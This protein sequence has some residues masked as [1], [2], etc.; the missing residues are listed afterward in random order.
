MTFEQ[1]LARTEEL[2]EG[3]AERAM[4]LLRAGGLGKEPVSPPAP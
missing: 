1:S 4:R 2:L 3:A